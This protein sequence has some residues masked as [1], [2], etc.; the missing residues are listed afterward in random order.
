MAVKK[1]QLRKRRSL[2]QKYGSFLEGLSRL[3]YKCRQKMINDAP[4]EVID[5]VGECCLNI[6][7]GNVHLTKAQKQQLRSRK[8]HIRLLSSKQV[9]LAAKKKIINQKGGALLGLLLKPLLGPIIGSVLSDLV[10]PPQQRH[11]G[12]AQNGYRS[13]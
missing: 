8:R 7:K 1:T 9:P 4:K 5:S 12:R 2:I 6:I 10:P 13:I 3:P 11:Y